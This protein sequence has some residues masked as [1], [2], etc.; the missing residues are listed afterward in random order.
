MCPKARAGI[1][2]CPQVA[3]LIAIMFLLRLESIGQPIA[4]EHQRIE[5]TL[6]SPWYVFTPYMGSLGDLELALSSLRIKQLSDRQ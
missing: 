3:L 4:F 6:R 5:V 2:Q 1:G